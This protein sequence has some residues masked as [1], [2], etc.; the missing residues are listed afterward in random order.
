[1]VV[2]FDYQLSKGFSDS[3]ADPGGGGE[4]PTMEKITSYEWKKLTNLNRITRWYF[5]VGELQKKKAREFQ[6]FWDFFLKMLL[7]IPHCSH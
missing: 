7:R 5:W 6:T 2:H 3:V 4:F 1:M